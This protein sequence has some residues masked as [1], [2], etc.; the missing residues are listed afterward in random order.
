MRQW[1]WIAPALLL[2]ACSKPNTPFAAAPASATSAAVPASAP[3]PSA[4]AALDGVEV[5]RDT[6][7]YVRVDESLDTRRNRPGDR[8]Q[9]TLYRDLAVKGSTVLPAGTVIVGHVTAASAS[10]RMKGRAVLALT[11]D[12]IRMEGG[13]RRIYTN[14][15]E[16]VSDSHKKRNIGFIGGGAGLGA[17]IGA[18][19]GGGKGAAIGAL[20]GGGAGTATAAATGKKDVGVA[21][22]TAM[23][24]RLESP[25]RL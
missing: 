10:G 5:P 16:R 3:V 15:V 1:I 9:A 24:F 12:A 11:L 6:P 18:I 21:A 2:A 8:F 19:A 7:L 14:T 23:T 17:A 4:P 25:I 22:E 20:A 13:E